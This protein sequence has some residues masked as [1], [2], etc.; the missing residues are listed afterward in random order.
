MSSHRP[1][2]ILPGNALA[3]ALNLGSYSLLWGVYPF[4]VTPLSLAPCGLQIIYQTHL[5]LPQGAPALTNCYS[6][7]ATQTQKAPIF[8]S[9]P[10]LLDAMLLIKGSDRAVT[11]PNLFGNRL[12]EEDSRKKAKLEEGWP[13]ETTNR[14]KAT[15]RSSS[16]EDGYRDTEEEESI[17]LGE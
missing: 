9:C 4:T 3:L 8:L 5:V 17:R 1:L 16:R 14:D 6:S 15:N 2:L 10:S 7:M 12:K 13:V 11:W